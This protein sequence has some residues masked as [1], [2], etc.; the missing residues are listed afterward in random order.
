MFWYATAGL[1]ALAI[2]FILIPL[3]RNRAIAG[4]TKA[5][6]ELA[7]VAVYR[8]RLVELDRELEFGQIEADQHRALVTD[9]QRSLLQNVPGNAA[10]T[11]ADE[12]HGTN[13]TC[14]RIA[15]ILFFIV[16]IPLG[17][18]KMYDQWGY[19]EEV[20]LSGLFRQALHGSNDPAEVTALI[21]R[22][23]EVAQQD[24]DNEWAWYFLGRNYL[25]LGMHQ[26][27]A[28]AYQRSVALFDNEGDRVAAMGQLVLA[29]YLAA[30]SILSPEIRTLAEQTLAINPSEQSA[31]RV[32]A[33]DARAQEN[34]AD[35]IRYWRRLVSANPSSAAAR[36]YQTNISAAEKRLDSNSTDE[37]VNSHS[38]TV[39]L[40]LADK[41]RLPGEMS[42]FI[43]A[44]NAQRKG[45]PPLAVARLSVAQLPTTIVL[46]DSAAVGPFNLSSADSV[47]VT[48]LIS[49]QG[50][51]NP[52]PGDY[53]QVSEPVSKLALNPVINIHITDLVE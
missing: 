21:M 33:S 2:L 37:S 30:D 42:V 5:D 18:Y 43:A 8:Q 17:S 23:K 50:N 6:L 14:L 53:R 49:R 32:L 15:V 4:S 46:D 36:V 7:N 22:L 45:M 16:L 39:Q 28:D 13:N 51:A 31:L 9:L 27:A 48:A 10:S 19:Y 47:Y 3:V 44:H 26:Q 12:D 35:A 40:K 20:H 38:V 52:Q 41:L 29:R 34:W 24:Q 11:P 25:T 1:L